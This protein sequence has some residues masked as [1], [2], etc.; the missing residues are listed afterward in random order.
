MLFDLPPDW[1]VLTNLL[2]ISNIKIVHLIGKTYNGITPE[3]IIKTLSGMLKFAHSNMNGEV[4]INNI[5]SRLS[6]SNRVILSCVN[7]LNKAKVINMQTPAKEQDDMIKYEFVG[8]ADLMSIKNLN[9]YDSFVETL[10]LTEEF[11]Y[12]LATMEIEDIQKLVNKFSAELVK[13]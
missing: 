13:I 10:K 5:A 3:Q 4:N 11:R 7:L 2:E 12:Q 6:T 8:S 1:K 9:E